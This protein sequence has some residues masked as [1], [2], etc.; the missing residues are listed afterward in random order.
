MWVRAMLKDLKG[1]GGVE[2]LVS[3]WQRRGL[4][5][6]KWLAILMEPFAILVDISTDQ[7]ETGPPECVHVS[8][9]SAT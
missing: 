2:S 7:A 6:Y 8:S 9:P 4:A 3:E 5:D 1:E